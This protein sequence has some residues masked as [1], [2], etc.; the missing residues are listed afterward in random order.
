M[1]R[2][3]FAALAVV[4]ACSDPK[5]ENPFDPATPVAL[6]ARATLAGTVSLE[7]PGVAAP[8]L[9][10]VTVS[11]AGLP[12]VTT[13][14]SGAWRL[15]GVPA[16]T[17]TVR[18]SNGATWETAS[19]T[20]VSVTLDDGGK[21][22]T[23]PEIRLRV[24]RGAISG[25]FLL[26]G[27]A[28]SAGVIVTLQG[29][30]FATVTDAAG[31]FALSG[32]P[33]GTYVVVAEKPDWQG[34]AVPG[35]AV[36]LGA[37]TVATPTPVTLPPVATASVAGTVLLEGG[38]AGTGA[39]VSLTG[40][41]FR[42]VAVATSTPAGPGGAF[43]FPNL[44]AGG[45]QVTFARD[46]FDAPPPIGVSVVTGQAASVGAVTL[47]VSRGTI[48]GTVALSSANVTGQFALGPDRSGVV[49]TLTGTDVPVPPA[50]TDA[51]GAYRFTGVPVS[52]AG[53][54]FTVQAA[55]P[56]F[57]PAGAWPTVTGVA[58]A[59]QGVPTITLEVAVASLT[60][61]ALLWDDVG[62]LGV[63]NDPSAGVAVAITG[64]AFNGT[65]YSAVAPGGTDGAGH[66]T[67]TGLPPGT[68]D[69][70]A[71][72]PGRACGGYPAA[73]LPAGA[74]VTLSSPVRCEDTVAPGPLALGTPLAGPGAQAGYT[75]A[76]SVTVPIATPASDATSPASNL[77]GYQLAVGAVPDWTTA[78]IAPGQPGS[79]TFTLPT[80]GGLP[81]D[82]TYLLFARAIDWIGNAGPA[83]TATVVVDHVAPAAPAIATSRNFVNATSASVTLS[84][85][86]T[87]PTFLRY[88]ACTGVSAAPATA[89]APTPQCVSPATPAP[90]VPSYAVQLSAN[91][92]NCIWARAVDRAGNASPYAV[93]EIVSDLLPPSGPGIA[94]IYD[95]A[96]FSVQASHVD[97]AI[98]E[99]ATDLPVGAGPWSGVAWVEVDTGGGFT[100]ICPEERCHPGGVYDPCSAACG[101]TD[102]RLRCDSTGFAAIRV[103][104]LS[105]AAGHVG[106]RAVD[107]AGNYGSGA[108]QDI[109]TAGVLQLLA[110]TSVSEGV[111]RVRGSTLVYDQNDQALLV[112]LGANQRFDASDTSCVIG[113]AW[114]SEALYQPLG[115]T[116]L[117]HADYPGPVRIRRRGA[118]GAW[119]SGDGTATLRSLP[120]GRNVQAVGAGYDAAGKERAAWVERDGTA[121]QSTVWVQE[122]GGDGLLG[123]A[124]D[125]PPTVITTVSNYVVAVQT[126][127]DWL[128]YRT[129]PYA[130]G[131]DSGTTVVVNR[132]SGG[133][134][135]A[136][137]T[138]YSPAALTATLT[139]DGR[140]LAWVSQSWASPQALHVQSPGANGRYEAGGDDVDVVRPLLGPAVYGGAIAADGGH[141]VLFEQGVEG[142]GASYLDHWYAGPNGAFEPAAGGVDDVF[143]RILPSNNFRAD[144]TLGT[145]L[146]GGVVYFGTRVL[147]DSDLQ[148]VD[149]SQ[150]RWEAITDAS[151]ANPTANH[152]GTVFYARATGGATARA[153]DGSETRSGL[154]HGYWM[155]ADG[156]D[157]VLDDGTGYQ[158]LWE[159][160]DGSGR[161]FT[162]GNP[163][164]ALTTRFTQ[165]YHQYPI[166]VAVGEGRVAFTAREADGVTNSVY[167]AEPNPT[168][169]TPLLTRLDGAPAGATVNYATTVG[170]S[171]RHAVHSCVAPSGFTQ[172]C[173]RELG[174]G[175]TF[176]GGSTFYLQKPGAASPYA[177][178]GDLK[179][180]RDRIGFRR[181]DGIFVVV[182]AG[183]D[184]AF[185]TADDVERVLFP[186]P[187]GPSNF[188]LAGDFVG[189]FA[190]GAPA[191]LQVWLADL[192]AGTSRQV[193][194][195][196]SAK[197]HVTVEPSGRV[198]WDDSAFSSRAVF[199][200]AP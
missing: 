105:G 13:D 35:Q 31:A 102:P 109:A 84:G 177:T 110:A 160:A 107:V 38:A 6:Q 60:G 130:S 36:T 78:A 90:T 43:S 4:T 30:G 186:V 179:V 169:A 52:L 50:V 28:S 55:R 137:V 9:G 70:L 114:Y 85:S 174:A 131:W 176:A 34:A 16:G 23:V 91:E 125:P 67:A 97:F 190:A 48:A 49:V 87:D 71:T 181:S 27:A 198:L 147:N 135:G 117:V 57:S 24:A 115:S 63:P 173:V 20:G 74:A 126:G 124:D 33:V 149:L 141:V 18:V 47:A 112:D 132:G 41:D 26:A 120:A 86:D 81:V 19:V 83:S 96:I 5:H 92:R 100:P 12:S 3:A 116:A 53:T 140:Q 103:P 62:G 56:D 152:A 154:G 151:A 195:H 199:V 29:T 138:T 159:P 32:V 157:V 128:L 200:S 44:V 162:G 39:T 1:R 184:H 42:G 15:E 54:A 17:Y 165:G 113:G 79:L 121:N 144:P 191:G 139:A 197:Q 11:V 10:G 182:D 161:F 168:L 187:Y 183:P 51:S 99:P 153:P 136:G 196:Y 37:A 148:A 145:G 72:D 123:T 133:F 171:A 68:Y 164:V 111:P 180:W 155:A 89:C 58:N 21:T 170:V 46:A 166:S 80:S 163:P 134:T 75:S 7:P 64:T 189:Y 82:G 22:V 194:H 93:A 127:G 118:G 101:C 88:E 142:G 69:V 77:R 192:G 122:S 158:L 172:I 108:T 104:L 185:D 25:T 178:T 66:W 129:S 188:D 14:D 143:E 76:A 167:V 59:T 61:T 106:V 95:P 156:G 146:A 45:Y 8:A 119:C 193:T 150:L 73:V 2:L 94:P 65:S 175:G 40:T 98:V